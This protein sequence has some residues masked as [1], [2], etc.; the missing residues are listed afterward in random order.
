LKFKKAKKKKKKEEKKK[1]CKEKKKN[2]KF[3]FCSDY[4]LTSEEKQPI[5]CTANGMLR[6]KI[7]KQH[8]VMKK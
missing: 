4:S 6:I 8:I 3:D 7:N 2:V 1:K 5:N